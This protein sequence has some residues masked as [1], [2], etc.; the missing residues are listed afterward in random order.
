MGP[1][2][3]QRAPRRALLASGIAELQPDP[4]R[5][6]GWTLLVNGVPQSYVDLSDP[7][8]LEFP[9]EI[10]LG[11][12][13]RLWSA[14]DV[15]EQ[16]LH[17]GGGGLTL[18]RFIDHLRPG[19]N[20]LVVE[21]DPQILAIVEQNLPFPASIEVRLGDARTELEAAD[22]GQ[23]GL[24]ISDVFVGAA[25]PES[26]AAGGFAR[27]ARRAL[28]PDGLLAMN[29]TDV[30]PLAQ[31]R[32]QVAT[33]RTAFDEIV[34]YGNADVMRGRRVGNVILL[35]GNVPMIKPGKHE[36]VL[37]GE[38]LRIFTA[39]ARPLLDEPR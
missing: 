23:F 9:Y 30:P 21:R 22:A 37:R 28:K 39:G 20:Q 5:A 35:A 2:G 29:L 36:S 25:M 16:V 17:L 6:R 3:N 11:A 32:I 1:L 8:H 38:E 27:A 7:G 34:L 33:A 14:H 31:T 24:I 18:P 19:T 26:V 13:L 10:Q 12:V 15:R 4:A